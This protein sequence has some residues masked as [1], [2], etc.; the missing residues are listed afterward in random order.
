MNLIIAFFLIA[1]EAMPEGLSDRGDKLIAGILESVYR[2]FVVLAL[3][4]TPFIVSMAEYW[5]WRHYWL[6]L[7]GYFLLRYALF[8]YIYNLSSGNSL[9]YI[10]KTKL[11]DRALRWF[12][13]VS[14][15][16][17]A[18]FLFMTKLITLPIAIV[19][20]LK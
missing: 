1:F 13:K 17:E 11:S 10:G 7:L 5:S 3:F 15:I 19:W 8:D 12:F 4:F 9:F 2:L 16:P 20:L 14:R 6:V 18:H